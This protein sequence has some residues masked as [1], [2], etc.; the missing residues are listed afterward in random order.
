MSPPASVAAVPRTAAESLFLSFLM[1]LLF[2]FC[3]TNATAQFSVGSDPAVNA[4]QHVL[5]ILVSPVLGEQAPTGT[6]FTTYLVDVTNRTDT[7]QHGTLYLTPTRGLFRDAQV[8]DAFSEAVIWVAPRART[9]LELSARGALGGAVDA[10]VLDKA[11]R[12]LG[13]GRGYASEIGAPHLFDPSG[14]S[15]IAGA[16]DG[17][18]L[19]QRP[20][21]PPGMQMPSVLDGRTTPPLI[22]KAT[23]AHLEDS[24]PLLPTRA[25]GY[26]SATL[27]LCP[28]DLL[29]RLPSE[30]LVAL[31]SWVLGG[32]SLALNVTRQTDLRH[33]ALVRLLGAAAEPSAAPAAL[34]DAQPIQMTPDPIDPA[35]QE[36]AASITLAPPAAVLPQL[37]GHRGGNLHPSRW[38]S[39]AT[40]GLGEVHLLGFD[41][42]RDPL[43][44]ERWTEYKLMDLLGHAWDR[45][46]TVALPHA[47]QD[48]K[49]HRV[50]SVRQFLRRN[51]HQH[52]AISA[53]ALS[54]IAYAVV[55]G[56]L[57]FRRARRRRKPF[58]ALVH[59]TLLSAIALC[60]VLAIGAF[61]RG[62]SERAQHL[63]LVDA[64]AGMSRAAATRFRAFHA[65]SLS[66][67]RV[68]ETERGSMLGVVNDADGMHT[69][70][71]TAAEGLSIRDIH[72][73]PWQALV[74]REEGFTNL[75]RGVAL[76]RNRAG[77]LLIANR[78]G[79][80]LAGVLVQ[81]AGG[82]LSFFPKI[83]DGEQRTFESGIKVEHTG[84]RSPTG[85]TALLVHHFDVLVDDVAPGAAQAWDAFEDLRVGEVDWWP[86]EVPVLL[87]QIV[88]GEGRTQ[89][90]GFEVESDRVLLR[91]TGFGG[92]P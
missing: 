42:E 17:A 31:G 63:T 68:V 41:P 55:A 2:V 29:V 43:T 48:P 22:V 91:V 11:E 74:V 18:P 14:V 34:L 44:T 26:A 4:K 5:E 25:S 62:T 10:V 78:L 92:E 56:P 82:A 21:P 85:T 38:G 57:N 54:L 39:S 19:P 75:G 50:Y 53:A 90:S 51:Q 13:M 64:G 23:R 24:T 86:E 61:T 73:K 16:L 79:R 12:T 70:V 37:I 87:G 32:G 6:G 71:V 15:R 66:Q 8:N 52:W 30:Q 80:D 40:Y 65:A 59:M 72:G 49:D 7:Q 36:V 60:S 81:N 27:V 77:G 20:P 1:T 58:A 47:E 28:T 3:P 67:L 83:P 46:S 45:R 35:A 9:T 76:V 69:R 84:A 33:A 88:G 89:D